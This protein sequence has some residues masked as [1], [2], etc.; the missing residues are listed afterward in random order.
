[1]SQRRKLSRIR[2]RRP[3]R[4]Q[5]MSEGNENSTLTRLQGI[6][7]EQGLVVKRGSLLAMQPIYGALRDLDRAGVKVRT[8]QRKED[9]QAFAIGNDNVLEPLKMQLWDMVANRPLE[10]AIEPGILVEGSY[11]VETLTSYKRPGLVLSHMERKTLEGKFVYSAQD[12]VA[13]MLEKI[14]PCV[15]EVPGLALDARAEEMA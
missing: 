12:A 7:D 3:G 10:I 2:A 6:L 4:L 9:V 5:G 14:A 11:H 13:W 8:S 1:M 15:A